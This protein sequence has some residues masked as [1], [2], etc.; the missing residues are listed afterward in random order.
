MVNYKHAECISYKD[1]NGIEAYGI[2]INNNEDRVEIVTLKKEHETSQR[3]FYMRF[4]SVA[5]AKVIVEKNRVLRNI[6]VLFEECY[7]PSYG[8]QTANNPVRYFEGIQNMFAIRESAAM[9]KLK[10]CKFF[11]TPSYMSID[12]KKDIDQSFFTEIF[13]EDPCSTIN[14]YTHKSSLIQKIYSQLTSANINYYKGFT[15]EVH[16]SPV[17]LGYFMHELMHN[18][19]GRIGGVRNRFDNN[20]VTVVPAGFQFAQQSTTSNKCVVVEIDVVDSLIPLLGIGITRQFKKVDRVSNASF[21]PLNIVKS[22]HFEFY[23]SDFK[24]KASVRFETS[25]QIPS[26][27]PLH[28]HAIFVEDDRIG[29]IYGDSDTIYEL[30]AV[31]DMPSKG[32]MGILWKTDGDIEFKLRITSMESFDSFVCSELKIVSLDELNRQVLLHPFKGLLTAPKKLVN[33]SKVERLHSDIVTFWL[34]EI[35]NH[36]GRGLQ[37]ILATQIKDWPSYSTV[38]ILREVLAVLRIDKTIIVKEDFAIEIDSEMR[39]QC[40]SLYENNRK[41]KSY[42]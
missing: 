29:N 23:F 2:I 24:I 33:L 30:I 3:L 32:K 17:F 34:T 22:I 19:G 21:I 25:L 6:L 10:L 14:L 20:R 9:I 41:R 11:T 39:A 18:C 12:R 36:A 35:V 31:E 27:T 16:A 42:D 4:L 37:G 40:S 8:R 26:G 38:E 15:T 28:S 5:E 13:L 1:D 7:D